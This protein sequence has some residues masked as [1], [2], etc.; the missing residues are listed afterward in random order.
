MLGCGT[1]LIIFALFAFIVFSLEAGDVEGTERA[2]IMVFF[3]IIMLSGLGFII[4]HFKMPKDERRLFG[5]REEHPEEGIRELSAAE[6][7]EWDRLGLGY[8]GNKLYCWKIPCSA[9][10]GTRIWKGTPGYGGSRPG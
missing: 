7:R 1:I 9:C 5:D 3:S 2:A 8:K 10:G 4:W 6:K